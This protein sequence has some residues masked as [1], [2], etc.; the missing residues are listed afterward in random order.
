MPSVNNDHIG[1]SRSSSSTE[2]MTDNGFVFMPLIGYS[3]LLY[4]WDKTDNTCIPL[5][6]KPTCSH[7]TEDCNAFFKGTFVCGYSL[8]QQDDFY[9]LWVNS[10]SGPS[11]WRCRLD[12]S[13]HEKV[14]SFHS[15][16]GPSGGSVLSSILYGNECFV[17]VSYPQDQKG[18]DVDGLFRVSLKTGEA[19]LITMSNDDTEWTEH[20]MYDLRIEDGLLYY[21]L[22]E[23]RPGEA[24]SRIFTYNISTR[25]NQLVFSSNKPCSFVAF[26][27]DLLICEYLWSENGF[28]ESEVFRYSPE[29]DTRIAVDIP[30]GYLTYD[31]NYLC[32]SDPDDNNPQFTLL[33]NDLQTVAVIRPDYSSHDGS[34]SRYCNEQYLIFRQTILKTVSDEKSELQ[35]VFQIYPKEEAGSSNPEAYELTFLLEDY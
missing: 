29:E 32:V 3:N 6:A 26:H 16:E 23:Y 12:G 27:G 8:Q 5:C 35:I 2:A 21:R 15:E 14:C 9:Y 11:L 7:D 10:L 34:I 33:D 17:Q 20:R 18:S 24:R 25:E 22:T 1:F 19:E 31:G 28:T 13:G 4:Y 30:P